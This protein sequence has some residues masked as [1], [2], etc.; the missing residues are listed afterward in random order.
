MKKSSER[1]TTTQGERPESE[2]EKRARLISHY[3]ETQIIGKNKSLDQTEEKILAEKY[4]NKSVA[5]KALELYQKMTVYTQTSREQ[6][7]T[8]EK[9]E[10]NVPAINSRLISRIKILYS[11]P[12]VC[13]LM[14]ATY[15]EARVERKAFR[16]AGLTKDWLILEESKR[17][18]RQQLDNLSRQLF[19]EKI[20]GA[21]NIEEAKTN[22]VELRENMEENGKVQTGIETLSGYEKTAENTDAAALIEYEKLNEY[23]R[24]L[25]E[26]NF[27][28]LPSREEIDTKA[29][30]VIESGNPKQTRKGIFFISE[31][32]SGKTE[33]I[34]AI[35][36]RLT[37]IEHAKISC[38]PR[39][40][41]PQLLGKEKVFPGATKIEEGTFTDFRDTVS[42]AWT[43]YDYSYQK[44]P[45]RLSS[46]V[47]EL[48]EMPKA[49][50]NETFF[51]RL[52]GFFAI[53]DGDK[54]P[55][56]DKLVLP[57][58]VVFGSGNVGVHHG[59]KPVPPALERE[60]EVIPVDYAEMSVENP[61]LYEF[62]L[63]CLI[64]EGTMSP[65]T[66]KDLPPAY[67]K[68]DLPENEREVL[69]DGS[70]VIAKDELIEDPTNKE[71]GFLYRL[72]FAV[73]AVQNSYMA[74][75]GE[76]PYIDYTKRELLRSKV[77][78]N[79]N[80]YIAETGDPVILGTTITLN[81]LN[82]W[83]RGYLEKIQ[84][85]N[86]PTLTDWL[87]EK[88]EEKI[89]AKYEDKDKIRAIFDHFHLLDKIT[90]KNMAKPLTPKEIGYL[91]P[92][93]P[94]PLYMEK[95]VTAEVAEM[96]APRSEKKEIKEYETNQVL[97]EDGSR[98][99]IKNNELI[100]PKGQFDLEKE[101][102]VPLEVA[103]GEKFI[104]GGESFVFAGVAEDK[105]SPYHG[106]PIGQFSSGEKLYKVFNLVELDTGRLEEFKNTSEKDLEN[107]DK[108]VDDFCEVEDPDAA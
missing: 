75:G 59:N 21:D 79:G 80:E 5:E 89:N 11:D 27:V 92:R 36:K 38:G 99:L 49:F 42:A 40:G 105:K 63:A 22:I 23:N 43:G 102:L 10:T 93:V 72:A 74:R 101:Q 81:D 45:T 97:L 6:N 20:L 24:Q 84:K 94:R 100:I 44:E 103:P 12:A 56:T 35:A 17:S 4:N 64:K 51:T 71:H 96:Q 85:K 34:R 57:G 31:P 98:I 16:T 8:I 9:S 55:G 86:A 106:Q 19:Q 46:Q 53:K 25:E 29:M 62:M 52:K 48:D 65:V 37:G 47:V 107:L 33:Q 15:G 32:G 108:D 91:S 1:F 73:K 70:V 26:E 13:A 69:S 68:N 28:W 30:K 77:D 2:Q 14:S 67:K 61:E 54:M 95:P 50:D 58:R 76:N 18:D 7:K 39:M 104:V 41:D 66:D 78:D 87:Q 3:I 88:L 83:M 60:I 90:D 82:G